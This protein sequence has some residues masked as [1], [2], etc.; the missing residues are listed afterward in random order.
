MFMPCFSC[1][2]I[3]Y[4]K[5]LIG[6]CSDS[7]V[8]LGFTASATGEHVLKTS[9]LGSEV[10]VKKTFQT[11]ELLKFPTHGLNEKF[12]YLAKVVGPS[13]TVLMFTAGNISYNCFSFETA[14]KI[15]L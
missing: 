3:F 1:S 7:V 2:N 12:Q 15:Q 9:F 4:I 10:T 14:F 11:G 5:D 13:G 6:T 8:D